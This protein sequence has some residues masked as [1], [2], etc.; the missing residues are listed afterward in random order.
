MWSKHRCET[1]EAHIPP[2][3]EMD[4]HSIQHWMTRFILEVRKK[5]GDKY[6]PN[7]LHHLV[8]G[9]MRFLRQN[10][11]PQLDF[12]KDAIFADFRC[13]LGE[14]VDEENTLWKRQILGDHYPQSLLHTVFMIGLYFALRSGDEHRQ[15]WY[16]PCQIQVV[17]KPGER[18]YLLYTEDISKNRPGGL[19]GR[20]CKPKMVTHYANLD[21]PSR[22]FVRIFKKYNSLCPPDRPHNAFY[23]SP[24]KQPTHDGWFSCVPV[25]R[26]KLASVVSTMCKLAGIGGYKTNHSLRATAATRLY[27]SGVNEQLVMERTGHR[28]TEGV[29]SYKRTSSEQ[30]EAVSDILSLR[31]RPCTEL[32]P[33]PPLLP[34]PVPSAA[35]VIPGS[36]TSDINMVNMPT[37]IST[38][39]STDH[40]RTFY[41]NSC[42]NFTINLN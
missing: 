13:F 2:P 16:N 21:N 32:Q 14:T 33:L 31:K 39:R 35:P 36:S 29:R 27:S 10:G 42:S 17:E 22:C 1:S 30:Q 6:P 20:K 12:F 18:P 26:N 4:A 28:S 25:G 9:I 24:L 11:N 41:F 8:C 38:A 7:T 15:L 34:H 23:L 37:H 19:K 40:A 3:T 5:N